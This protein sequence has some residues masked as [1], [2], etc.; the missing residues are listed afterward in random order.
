ML[1]RVWLVLPFVWLY[2]ASAR[3]VD[4]DRRI[5]QYA[6][7]VWRTQDG[8]FQGTPTAIVQTQDGYLWLGTTSDLVR[9]DGVRF[10]P[11]SS[12][13]GEQLPDVQINAL[14]A[15]RDGTLWIGT[16]GGLSHWK[17]HTL[18]N[19]PAGPSPTVTTILEDRQGTIWFGQGPRPEAGTL[20]QV[21]GSS[22]RCLGIADGVPPFLWKR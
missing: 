3:A 2:P 11:F 10:A 21:V 14:L 18:T 19:Y 13:H 7:A 8:L 15:A 6:H 1:R 5:S 16:Q 17:N 20:C 22:T 9:F 12:E 4:P